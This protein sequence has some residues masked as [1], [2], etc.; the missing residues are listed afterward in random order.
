MSSDASTEIQAPATQLVEQVPA[1]QRSMKVVEAGFGTSDAFDLIQRQAKALSSSTLVPTVYQGNVANAMIALEVSHRVNASPFLVMQNLDIIQGRPS[2]KSQ[3]LIGIT[4]SSGRFSPLRFTFTGE[5]GKSSWGC[6]CSAIEYAS[7]E[8]LT[9]ETI[10]ME[11]AEKEGWLNKNGSKW[12]TM[13]GQ[14]LRYRAASF[15]V[16]IHA[17]EL[18]LGLYTAEEREDIVEAEEVRPTRSNAI[19]V[20]RTSLLNIADVN[21][22]Q[23]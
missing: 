22:V 14:M 20:K 5:Q 21:A 11:M 17:P 6:F 4:N 23:E 19:Q 8:V 13:P 15:W 10:T 3:F 9:G 7:G 16:R 12:K 2:W 1:Q 18:A